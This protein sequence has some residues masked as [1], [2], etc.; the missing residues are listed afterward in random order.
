MSLSTEQGSIPSSAVKFIF[1]GKLFHG[2]Y[3]VGISVFQRLC[4]S[5]SCVV[6]GGGPSSLLVTVQGSPLTV[7]MLLNMVY[8]NFQ[9]TWNGDKS[10]KRKVK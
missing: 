10:H 7:F 3:S 1:S 8:R 2:M 6:I 5:M 4:P 9:I